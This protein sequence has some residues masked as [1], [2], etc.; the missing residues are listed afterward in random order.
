M[1]RFEKNLELGN[2]GE[3]VVADHLKSLDCGVIPSYDYKTANEKAPRLQ[4]K[5]ESCVLPDLDCCGKDRFWCEVKTYWS[6]VENRTYN[7]MVH[8]IKRRHY[9]DYIKVQDSTKTEVILMIFELENMNLIM[10]RLSALK[11]YDCLCKACKTGSGRCYARPR[12]CVYFNRA[13]FKMI[14]NIDTE[15]A[16]SLR[17]EWREAQNG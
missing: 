4:F 17:S 9:F 5:D 6:A 12:D 15:A 7:I 13:Q 16:K 14:G 2:K 11:V 10:S 3:L 1:N 8:G